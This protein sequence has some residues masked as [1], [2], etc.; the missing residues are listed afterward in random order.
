M[1]L[2]LVEDNEL[3]IELFDDVLSSDGHD[4]V[5]ARDGLAGRALGAG[6]DWDLIL[7]DLRLPGLPGEEV[8][9]SLRAAGVTAPIVALSSSAMPDQIEHALPAGFDGYLT[10]PIAPK[11]LRAAVRFYARAA[12]DAL[13]E[14]VGR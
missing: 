7:L 2:L 8:C 9:R 13:T 4:V 6:G 10:K 5:V 1:R 14:A 12:E 3:N 11:A